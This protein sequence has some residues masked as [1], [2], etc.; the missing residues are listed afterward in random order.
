MRVFFDELLAARC[1]TY[2]GFAGRQVSQVDAG[3]GTAAARIQPLDASST[4]CS[5]LLLVYNR[6]VQARSVGRQP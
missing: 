5:T 3:C 2:N 4:N 6:P 1:Q